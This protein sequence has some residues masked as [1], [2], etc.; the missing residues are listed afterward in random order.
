MARK[1]GWKEEAAYGTD[2]LATPATDQV[3]YFG[4]DDFDW[5]H[6]WTEQKNTL[7]AQND[8]LVAVQAVP[9]MKNMAWKHKSYLVSA[10]EWKYALGDVSGAGPYVFKVGSADWKSRTVYS[11]IGDDVVHATGMYTKD[12]DFHAGIGQAHQFDIG[13]IGKDAAMSAAYKITTATGGGPVIHKAS[14]NS[15]LAWG[16][17]HNNLFEFNDV[18][19]KGQLSRVHVGVHNVLAPKESIF[20]D[21]VQGWERVAA[22]IIVDFDCWLDGTTNDLASKIRALDAWAAADS[23][24]VEFKFLRN[25]SYYQN[26]QVHNVKFETIKIPV[27]NKKVVGY[28]IVGV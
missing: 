9:Q 4:V 2:P 7:L 14:L 1:L 17:N 3:Q 10:D 5:E 13:M 20:Y 6:P 25:T 23:N 27:S 21:E 8:Q 24:D 19:L 26:I 16:W 15:N 11:E 22:A 12:F 28:T 18:D